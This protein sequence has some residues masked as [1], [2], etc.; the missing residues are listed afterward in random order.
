MKTSIVIHK[1][2]EYKAEYVWTYSNKKLDK[3]VHSKLTFGGLKDLLNILT[4]AH[5]ILTNKE[6]YVKRSKNLDCFICKKK[7]IDKKVFFYLDRAWGDGIMHYMKVH[8]IEPSIKFK[9]FIYNKLLNQLELELKSKPKIS[10]IKLDTLG[11]K[12]D[13]SR[14]TEPVKL[15]PIILEKVK[16]NNEE[17]VKFDRNKIL[18]LDALMI[19]G[20]KYKKYFDPYDSSIKKYSE[21]AGFLDFENSKLQKIVVSGQ[22][23]RIDKED[24]E[25][26]LPKDMD[27]MF[28]YEY[29]FHTHPPTPKEGGR[30]DVGIL[31]ELP[32]I[33]DLYHFIDHYNEG[34][35]IGSLVVTPEGLY[36]IRR[37]YDK[38]GILAKMEKSKDIERTKSITRYVH[39][40]KTKLKTRTKNIPLNKKFEPDEINIDD[41]DLY[42]DYRKIFRTIQREAIHKHGTEYTKE[43]FYSE[44]AQDLTNFIK[45]FNRVLNKYQLH[46]DFYPRK[47]DGIYWY[48]E[49]VFLKFKTNINLSTI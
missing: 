38:D 31:Y 43:Y 32:S 47:K 26:F 17:Y 23:D 20:G 25:I 6:R 39:K 10:N 36:N 28:E 3:P 40:P 12:A 4:I 15:E 21:H 34:N 7:N 11:R 19:M 8:N 29:I 48:I 46:V 45:R 16:I 33:G 9:D 24:S 5:E 49:T 18:I 2:E 14:K 22:T 35:V 27:E 1:D 37:F 30:A 44:I 42:D 41:D 13:K